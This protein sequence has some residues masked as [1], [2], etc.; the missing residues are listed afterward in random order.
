MSLGFEVDCERDREMKTYGHW[1][2]EDL[3]ACDIDLFLSHV[4]IPYSWPYIFAF[5]K[6]GTQLGSAV[7]HLPP[8]G[9]PVD[10]SLTALLTSWLPDRLTILS[11]GTCVYI[12]S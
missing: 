1:L 5:M 9:V 3:E 12:I 2:T 8:T 7:N 11:V 10:H 6:S 4:M